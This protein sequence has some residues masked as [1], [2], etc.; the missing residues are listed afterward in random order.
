M[1]AARDQ[2]NLA[3]THNRRAADKSLNNGVRGL[4]LKTP[5]K[6]TTKAPFK[7][8]GNDENNPRGFGGK[9]TILKKDGKQDKNAFVTPLGTDVQMRAMVQR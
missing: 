9:N 2:E 6:Q 4:P 1:L 5:A 3:Y 7:T 8:P